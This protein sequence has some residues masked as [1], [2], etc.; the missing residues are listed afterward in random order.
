MKPQSLLLMA[1][2]VLGLLCLTNSANAQPSRVPPAPVLRQ[3]PPANYGYYQPRIPPNYHLLSFEE[4]RILRDGEISPGQVFGGGVLAVFFGFGTG[5]AVQGRWSSTGWK[6]AL[7]EVAGFTAI[8][9]GA[10]SSIS[11]SGRR[12][13]NS[14]GQ[15]LMIGG[16][17]TFGVSRLWEIVDAFATPGQHNSR[18]RQVQW[19]AYGNQPYAPQYSLFVTPNNDTGGGIAG[20]KMSF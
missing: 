17:V 6:F 13:T 1:S 11:H 10:T 9:I 15:A 14:S 8:I 5:Q 19:K 18:Y 4:Q 2:L 7:A 20:L 3:A 16:L 12:N